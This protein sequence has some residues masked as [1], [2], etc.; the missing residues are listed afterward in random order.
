MSNVWEYFYAYQKNNDGHF[1]TC[2]DCCRESRIRISKK[3]EKYYKKNS[4]KELRKKFNLR[5]IKPEKIP[6]IS[7]GR[8]FESSDRRTNRICDYCKQK[9]FPGS[10]FEEEVI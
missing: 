6:C 5:P 8:I 1:N 4:V 2:K 10:F 3:N 7:C 9:R